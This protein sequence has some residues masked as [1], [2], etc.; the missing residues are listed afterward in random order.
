[1]LYA[2]RNLPQ[3]TSNTVSNNSR[4]HNKYDYISDKFTSLKNNSTSSSISSNSSS[5]ATNSSLN[6]AVCNA[7]Y[8]EPKYPMNYQTKPANN[9]MATL[10]KQSLKNITNPVYNLPRFSYLTL[11]PSLKKNQQR[12]TSND[13][14]LDDHSSQFKKVD[15]FTPKHNKKHV[16]IFCILIWFIVEKLNNFFFSNP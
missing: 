1:M 9:G 5:S 4:S 14:D 3:S 16:N 10:T 15:L 12:R 2:E 13:F 7:T 6:G 8:I 11:S